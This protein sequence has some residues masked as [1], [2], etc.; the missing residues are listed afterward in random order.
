MPV[1]IEMIVIAAEAASDVLVERVRGR[2]PGVPAQVLA[3]EAPAG[4]PPPGTLA[5]SRRRGAF[6]KTFRL[7]EK[8]PP[9]GERYVVPLVGCP[10]SCAYC[11]LQSYLE[12]SGLTVFTDTGRMADEIRA[13]LRDDP[14]IRLTTG[15][16]GD[17]LAL[18]AVTGTTLD[19]L[20]LLEGT[21]A[22]LDARTKSASIDHLLAAAGAAGSEPPD[23]RLAA[24][25]RRHLVIAWTMTPAEAIGREEPG[26]APLEARLDAMRRAAAAGLRVG[27]RLD[28]VIPAYARE[29]D[30]RRLVGLVAGALGP[31]GPERVE[32]G[33][34][35]FPLGL[36]D[37][38]RRRRPR[39]A[40]LRGEWIRDADGKER[41]NRPARVRLYRT[42]AAIVRERFPG[43]GIELS[44][45]PAEVW[46][47]AEVSFPPRCRRREG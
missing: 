46:E 38:V 40:V 12:T 4:G 9:C 39:S 18:D 44:M 41:L 14:L 43:T 24:L 37:V 19:I 35:R 15:E 2:L 8:A 47:D 3:G 26:T 33:V 20:P 11:Y 21:G 34:L 30:Y 13:A 5:L 23:P 32:I 36:R 31:D 42:I 1:K 29:N 22:L 25:M 17:S 10:F 27:V 6:V 7:P 28:P 45:E 16:F